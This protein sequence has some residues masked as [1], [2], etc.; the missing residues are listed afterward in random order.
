MEII[1]RRGFTLI[2]FLIALVIIGFIV[3]LL[4]GVFSS[5]VRQSSLDAKVAKVKDGLRQL[6]AA[7]ETLA[8]QGKCDNGTLDSWDCFDKTVELGSMT[9]MPEIPDGV[10]DGSGNSDYGSTNKRAGGCGPLNA[11]AE[12]RHSGR[13]GYVSLD[14]CKAYN[15]AQGQAELPIENCTSGA[16]C[17]AS[18]SADNYDF[19]TGLPA[20]FCYR[21]DDHFSVIMV[22]NVV[23]PPC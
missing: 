16:D 11:G 6:N 5:P 19:P 13:L 14:F 20:T 12:R 3:S 18:G 15:K 7:A 4:V 1:M 22:S 23:G 8:L 10:T 9:A 21:Q 17:T 2:E